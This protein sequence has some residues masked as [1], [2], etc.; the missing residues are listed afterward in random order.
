MLGGGGRVNSEARIIK[1]IRQDI[2]MLFSEFLPH[3][4]DVLMWNSSNMYADF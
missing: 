3:I 1:I 2:Q 4:I